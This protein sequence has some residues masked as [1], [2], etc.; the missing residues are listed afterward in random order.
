MVLTLETFE[1]VDALL[2]EQS[3]N[4][5]TLSVGEE[6]VLTTTLSNLS[7]EAVTSIGFTVLLDELMTGLR[8]SSDVEMLS[9]MC[10]VGEFAAA[11]CL[12]RIVARRWSAGS[13]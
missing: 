3:L 12:G 13:R 8:P 11:Q 9:T 6:A 7:A 1:I 2:A 5:T 10:V 4:Q